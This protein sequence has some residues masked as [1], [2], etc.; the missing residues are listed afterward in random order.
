M[1]N[2]KQTT[3]DTAVEDIKQW[4]ISHRSNPGASKTRYKGVTSRESETLNEI[5]KKLSL[6]LI[7]LLS[8]FKLNVFYNNEKNVCVY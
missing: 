7:F 1:A 4:G 6:H 2:K 8:K 5:S 3:L